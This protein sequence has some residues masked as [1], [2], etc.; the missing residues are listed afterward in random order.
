M[1][2]Q[3]ITGRRVANRIAGCGCAGAPTAALWRRGHF[4]RRLR[5]FCGAGPAAEHRSDIAVLRL[6]ATPMRARA[7]WGVGPPAPDAPLT[8]A[9]HALSAACTL[10]ASGLQALARSV[11]LASTVKKL[12]ITRTAG[13]LWA[14]RQ[15]RAV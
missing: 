2:H 8:D 5:R 12:A 14:L 6:Y 11:L 3:F 7:V 13:L 10:P 4:D 1:L 9:T 15:R